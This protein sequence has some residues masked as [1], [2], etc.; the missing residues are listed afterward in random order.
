MIQN[1]DFI[2]AG[3][4]VS[5]NGKPNRIIFVNP[6][7]VILIEL[8]IEKFHFETINFNLFISISPNYVK[9]IEDIYYIQHVD[10]SMEKFEK[11]TEMAKDIEDIL[12]A[13]HPHY[14]KF[15]SKETIPVMNFF[16]QKYGLS[17]K[18]TNKIIRRYLQTGRDMYALLDMR[19]FNKR[20]M[21]SNLDEAQQKIFKHAFNEF[22]RGDVKSVTA[23]YNNMIIN[24]YSE[25]TCDETGKITDVTPLPKNSR[26]SEKVFRAFVKSEIGNMSI[27][28]FKKTRSERI[29]TDRIQ[30]GNAQTGSIHPGD[31]VEIDACEIDFIA[32]S[33]NCQ[34]H[35]I[36]RPV[37]YFV[38]DT[39]SNCI[40][41]YYVGLENNSFM[42]ASS[43]FTNLF[44][45]DNPHERNK[46]GLKKV[47]ITPGGIIPNCIRVDHGSEWIS[48]DIRRF[49]KE[50]RI[51]ETIVSPGVGSLKGLVESSFRSF[52]VGLR[53]IGIKFGAIYPEY[54]SKHYDKASLILSEVRE[55]VEDFIIMF[56]QKELNSYTL[57]QN[58]ISAN[59]RAVPCE[60]W[61]YGINYC[62]NP[63]YV[64][65]TQEVNLV[66]ALCK[67]C[68]KDMKS[69]L[70]LE[71]IIIK[72]LKYINKDPRLIDLIERKHFS[73]KKVEYEARYDPRLIDYIW[74]KIKN[75]ILKVP[76]AD[77]KENQMSFEGLT[78][79]EYNL[80]Y[81]DSKENHKSY[82]EINDRVK[83]TYVAQSQQI[84]E[85]SKEQQNLIPGKNV[86]TGITKQRTVDREIERKNSALVNYVGCE[87]QQ[88]PA[89]GNNTL[90]IEAIDLNIVAIESANDSNTPVK[91][92][93]LS[94][95]S[96]ED[97]E[98]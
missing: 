83:L 26:P 3:N 42:G 63:R 13:I 43:L 92:D 24:H 67:P 57:S 47:N 75:E 32:I 60:L 34:K 78:W 8:G 88:L 2:R 19:N 91:D 44:F 56:N 46:A 68:T 77:K 72:G 41:G 71:G 94:Y 84:M 9:E 30:Y 7:I 81:V 93:Y 4:V 95:F 36:G 49:T 58:M 89:E 22:K 40:L 59:V 20:S 64:T 33:E 76:L 39:F 18:T 29:N 98:D 37:I 14:S 1:I 66:F 54:D 28:A 86:K 15:S 25:I 6:E 23:A 17:S 51:D 79:F 73:K 45:L 97:E 80:Y 21:N 82:K 62:G 53:D 5:F 55:I 65:K 96:W 48:D 50:C 90:A 12:K 27:N 74:V 69:D 10:I 11:I 87:E 16:Q 52:Q 35:G 31:I 38:V 85:K 61:D 70:T